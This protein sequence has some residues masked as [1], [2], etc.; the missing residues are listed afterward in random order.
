[1]LN[2]GKYELRAYKNNNRTNNNHH[3]LRMCASY[4]CKAVEW[5]MCVQVHYHMQI[6]NHFACILPH[7]C[8]HRIQV[9]S[10]FKTHQLST[11]TSI[12]SSDETVGTFPHIF[13]LDE[14]LLLSFV[15]RLVCDQLSVVIIFITFTIAISILIWP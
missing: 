9:W 15:V 6:C 12:N 13:P 4:V 5:C 7:N 8:M 1:M 2:D 11:E 10:P 14:F 3:L